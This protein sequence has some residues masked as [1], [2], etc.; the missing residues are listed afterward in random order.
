MVKRTRQQ[1]N[2]IAELE[3][4]DIRCNKAIGLTLGHP[5]G[6]QNIQPSRTVRDSAP[7]T[8]RNSGRNKYAHGT[9]SAVRRRA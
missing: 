2:Q 6:G 4:N 1:T 3:Q 8:L 9:Y 7:R 5:D